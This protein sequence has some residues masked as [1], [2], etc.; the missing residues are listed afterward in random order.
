M[1]ID[2]ALLVALLVTGTTL[3]VRASIQGFIPALVSATIEWRLKRAP[4]AARPRI[5]SK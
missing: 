3:L 2:T 5:E 1:K 4:A